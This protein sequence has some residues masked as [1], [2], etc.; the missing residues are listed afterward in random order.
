MT[1]IHLPEPYAGSLMTCIHALR[2]ASFIVVNR[3]VYKLSLLCVRAA[4]LHKRH[5][6]GRV[7]SPAFQKYSVLC[8]RID[9]DRG[10]TK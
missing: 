2:F 10:A 9:I 6:V 4:D 7:L 1:C 3:P 5:T 8:D